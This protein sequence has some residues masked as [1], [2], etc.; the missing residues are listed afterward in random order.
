MPHAERTNAILLL[1][2]KTMYFY[3]AQAWPLD[4]YAAVRNAT[5]LDIL[6]GAVPT[7]L[8]SGGDVGL[9]AGIEGKKKM[10]REEYER[11]LGQMKVLVGIGSPVIS[12]SPY[13]AL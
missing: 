11:L 10:G 8:E 1:A 4:W 7:P 9:P 13:N 5:G 6:S 12:P 2:K 3:R